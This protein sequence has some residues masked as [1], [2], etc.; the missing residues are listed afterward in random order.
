MREIREPLWLP[1]IDADTERSHIVKCVELEHW[2]IAQVLAFTLGL[3]HPRFWS[4]SK[5][6][7]DSAEAALNEQIKSLVIGIEC[8]SN[9]CPDCECETCGTENPPPATPQIGT[10]TGL[11]VDE[12]EVE[13]MSF[14]PQFQCKDGVIQMWNSA[15][16]EWENFCNVAGIAKGADALYDDFGNLIG[17]LAEPISSWS[18]KELSWGQDPTFPLEVE[19]PTIVTGDWKRCVKATALVYA[20]YDV[21]QQGHDAI[22][23]TAD[24]AEAAITFVGGIVSYLTGG[25]VIAEAIAVRE[26]IDHL[27]DVGLGDLQ[28]FIDDE[29]TK[30]DLVCSVTGQMTYTDELTGKDFSGLWLGLAAFELEF[31]SEIYEALGAAP[32]ASVRT[33]AYEIVGTGACACEQYI[34]DITLPVPT[35]SFRFDFVGRA[36]ATDPSGSCGLPTTYVGQTYGWALLDVNGALWQDLVSTTFLCESSSQDNSYM[37]LLV[38]FSEPA[39]I[40]DVKLYGFLGTTSGT[41]YADLWGWHQ[42]TQAWI[43]AGG[44]TGLNG[45][46]GSQVYDVLSGTVNDIDKLVI[47]LKTRAATAAQFYTTDVRITGTYQGQAF[48]DLPIGQLFT[49]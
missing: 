46:A 5:S 7:Y 8:T 27:Q 20:L 15:C 24:L 34:P 38:E 9:E 3:Q 43:D 30:N 28:T 2:F 25:S 19:D 45:A 14:I 22:E 10:V 44:A 35:G 32:A 13:L 6:G 29:D 17:N 39:T 36:K 1:Q 31:V 41:P 12:L 49:P 47:S 26:F 23:N 11:T 48:T 16:C 18:D 4:G 40:T 37:G 42:P 21:L 33:R